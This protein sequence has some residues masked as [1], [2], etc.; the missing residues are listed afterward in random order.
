MMPKALLRSLPARTTVGS[1]VFMAAGVMLVPLALP[2]CSREPETADVAPA[3]SVADAATVA[4][5]NKAVGLMGRFEFE[6][7]AEA[8]AAVA[9]RTGAPVEAA[10][11]RAIATL[12]QSRDGAQDEALAQLG[13]IIAAKPSRD[14]EL[15]ARYC[16]GLC[17]LYLGRAGE[18]VAA[19]LPV[20]EARGAD[21]YA[22]YFTAQALEQ[23]GETAKALGWYRQ[24]ADRDPYLKSALLGVQRCA[25]KEGDEKAAE[26]ALAAFERLAENPRARAA[27]FKYTRM[28]AM[29]MAVVPLDASKPAYAPPAG[30]IFTEERELP[31]EWP[32]GF[33]PEWSGDIDQHAATVDLD[34]DGVQDIVIARALMMPVG[35][36]RKAL[37]LVLKGRAG[38]PY[39]AEPMHTLSELAGDRVNSLLF[40]DIDADGRVDCYACCNGGNRLLLQQADGSFRDATDSAK[41]RGRMTLCPDG[42]LADLDHDGDLDIFLLGGDSA[43]ELLVNNLDGTFREIG[44]QAG[45]ATSERG[46]RSVMVSDLD[47]DRDADIVVINSTPPHEVL[48]NDRLWKW[49]P[50]LAPGVTEKQI[51]EDALGAAVVELAD[52]PLRRIVLVASSYLKLPTR[53][54]PFAAN[55]GVEVGTADVTGDGHVDIVLSGLD[56]VS[57]H[58]TAGREVFSMPAAEGA[59]HTQLVMLEPEKGASLLSLRVGKPPLVRDPGAGRGNIAAVS[60]S[61]RTDPS[62][63]MRSNTSGIGTSYA[64]RVGTEWFG[65]ETFRTH[66]GRGQSLAPVAIGMGPFDAAD[67]IEIEWSDGVFQTELDVRAGGRHAIAETQRQISSCPVLFAW[68]GREMRFVTDVLGVG[69]VGYL[70]EPGVYSEPRP[71]EFLVLP[72]PALVPREDGSLSLALAEPMEES[73]MLDAVRLRAVDLPEGWDIAPDER[74]AIGGA[75]PTGELVAWRRAWLPQGS[76]ALASV[77]LVAPDVGA[78]DPRFIGRLAGE[79]SVELEFGTAIDAIS[80]PWLVID[81]WVE[82]PYCQ[83]MFAAWQAGAKY[84]APSLEARAADGTWTTLVEEWGYPAGMPRRM[85]LPVPREKLPAGATAL[86]LRTNMEVYFDS[87][88]LVAREPLP[89]APFELELA[90]ATLASVGFARRTTGPQKQPFYDRGDLLPLWDC[91]FQRGLYTDLGDVRAQ[92]SATD[93]EI[94]VFGPGEEVAFD[95]AAAPAPA[96]TGSVRRYILESRGWC[97]DMDLFTKDGET[98]APLPAGAAA[99]SLRRPMGGR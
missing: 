11:G 49:S 97:K 90:R 13:A 23:V 10:L 48:L 5:L 36:A 29:G 15:R 30:P 81:G 42:A 96:A 43:N 57:V 89:S 41:A 65:G 88:R 77:D 56:R 68:N 84:R 75:A 70:L 86:R 12:N 40:G 38:Q 83:T 20:A 35:S 51:G 72:E 47:Y 64:A 76:E 7:A 85:A 17:F 8:F 3:R 60:F 52:I 25:R 32:A 44:A 55:R 91:R 34:G 71:W 92:L 66:T 6:A 24:A 87:V 14:L 4:E 59:V 67:F 21:A 37:P 50:G 1:A 33:T 73:C 54:E 80:E 26:A 99:G 39:L 2:S 98:I 22:S 58:D 19:F 45:I 78:H 61:G 16:Q 46:P 95:F 18:A 94:V 62:Q 69:G 27:E 93:G 79:Q 63:S 28:G 82:Y 31:I 74:L 53:I 9:A